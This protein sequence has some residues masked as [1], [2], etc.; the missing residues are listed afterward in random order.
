VKMQ[1]VAYVVCLLL[2]GCSLICP[3]PPEPK[4][5]PPITVYVKPECG[6]PPTVE[7]FDP[8][9]VT[10]TVLDHEGKE[11]FALEADEYETLGKATNGLIKSVKELAAQRDFWRTC[12]ERAKTG[13][14]GGGSNGGG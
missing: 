3:K 14:S 5:S 1:H 2:P 12:V 9:P 6:V 8:A 7:Q 11:F 13:G 4:P 10:W